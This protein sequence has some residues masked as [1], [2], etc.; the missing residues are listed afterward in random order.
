MLAKGTE[1]NMDIIISD[2][3]TIKQKYNQSD[4]LFNPLKC[5]DNSIDWMNYYFLGINPTKIC[6]KGTEYEAIPLSVVARTTGDDGKY[7]FIYMQ[8]NK[9]TGEYYIGKVNRKRWTE[10]KRYQGSGLRFVKKYNKHKEEFVRYFI[11]ACNTSKE[12]EDLEARIVDSDLLQDNKCLN[13]VTGGGGIATVQDSEVRK[14][15]LRSYM[16]AHPEQSIAMIEKSKE[17]YCSGITPELIKRGQ[18]IKETMSS[19]YYKDMMSERI[20]KWRENNPEAYEKARQ[21]NKDVMQSEATR[22]KKREAYARWKEENP[23]QYKCVRKAALIACT[24]PEANK[25]RANSIKKWNRENPEQARANAHK[26]S[27]ASVEVCK[28]GVNML[29]LKSGDIIKSFESQHDAARWLVENGYAKNTNCVSSISAVCL[30]KPCTTGYGY[31][32]KAYGFGW[33]FIK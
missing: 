13:L 27:I 6:I 11:A 1:E 19:D 30:K 5:S 32:K 29:D 14:A 4:K 8:I 23:E 25:K 15:K 3:V 9:N 10:V 24:T 22:Q 2:K 31:R 26:R 21:K 16:I 18:K 7:H 28:K 20:R 33:E 12:T 17:L